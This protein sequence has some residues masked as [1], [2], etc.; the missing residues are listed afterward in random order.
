MR[1]KARDQRC[2]DRKD[3]IMIQRTGFLRKDTGATQDF[4]PVRY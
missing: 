2:N 1:I 4:L 3:G